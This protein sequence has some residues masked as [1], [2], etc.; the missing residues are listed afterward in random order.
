MQVAEIKRLNKIERDFEIHAHKT[1]QVPLT[2]DNILADHL[3]LSGDPTTSTGDTHHQNHSQTAADNLLTDLASQSST[4]SARP[5]ASFLNTEPSI[6][7]I[8]LNT[9]IISNQYTDQRD[10]EGVD[11]ESTLYN[12]QSMQRILCG[13]VCDI[14]SFLP[15]NRPSK[16]RADVAHQ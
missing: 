1:L 5:A 13:N 15:W 3:L 9:T 7:E 11:G 14:F 8:I 12:G 4:A 10:A 6:N 16:R 2:A